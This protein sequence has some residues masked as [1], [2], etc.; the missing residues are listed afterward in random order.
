MYI[1]HFEMLPSFDKLGRQPYNF[2]G[3]ATNVDMPHNIWALATSN[4]LL[5]MLLRMKLYGPVVFKP[6][7]RNNTTGR[8]KM[9]SI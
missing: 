1:N 4:P 8:Y 3:L 6:H 2:N 5:M 7:P 9:Q